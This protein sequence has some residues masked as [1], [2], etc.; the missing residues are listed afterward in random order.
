MEKTDTAT[1]GCSHCGRTRALVDGLCDDCTLE[2]KGSLF[3]FPRLPHPADLAESEVAASARREEREKIAKQLLEVGYGRAAEFVGAHGQEKKTSGSFTYKPDPLLLAEEHERGRRQGK[4][5]AYRETAHLRNENAHQKALI[6]GLRGDLEVMR[7]RMAETE[8]PAVTWFPEGSVRT[9]TMQPLPEPQ[10]YRD[11]VARLKDPALTDDEFLTLFQRFDFTPETP[12]SR[13]D[14]L[15]IFEAVLERNNAVLSHLGN[16]ISPGN[17][18]VAFD[19]LCGNLRVFQKKIG[20]VLRL[21]A[22]DLG[23]GYRIGL[24]VVGVDLAKEGADQSVVE[25]LSKNATFRDDTDLEAAWIKIID[26]VEN[27]A[28]ILNTTANPRLF[29][30]MKVKALVCLIRTILAGLDALSDLIL[31]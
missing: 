14:L 31:A 21:V 30:S 4:S 19:F 2:L 22:E 24:N 6:L 1:L 9:Y 3:P 12:L 27:L 29:S 23:D 18:Y 5:E 11:Q 8:I 15:G 25:W 13:E 26:R 7:G 16:H 17:H 10:L 20:K 28:T